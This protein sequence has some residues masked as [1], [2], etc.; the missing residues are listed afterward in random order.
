MEKGRAI[1]SKSAP[2]GHEEPAAR[3]R[4]KKMAHRRHSRDARRGLRVGYSATDETC[5]IARI[6]TMSC[7]N[8]GPFD[9]IE[10]LGTAQEGRLDLQ[11]VDMLPDGERAFV[12]SSRAHVRPWVL[13]TALQRCWTGA[14][15]AL[16][17]TSP[18]RGTAEP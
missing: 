14:R 8:P 2:A 5:Q 1:S 7:G 3:K 6:P 12:R 9:R 15:R 18:L 11:E 13:H 17:N 16:L 10:G 4:P